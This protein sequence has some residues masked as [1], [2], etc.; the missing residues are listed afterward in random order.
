M[1]FFFGVNI[2]WAVNLARGRIFLASAQILFLEIFIKEIPWLLGWR[3]SYTFLY[4][5]FKNLVTS[6][7]HWREL[8]DI[9]D[10]PDGGTVSI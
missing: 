7:L 2:R 1:P 4:T 3:V 6:L 5:G 8:V 10:Q 9:H